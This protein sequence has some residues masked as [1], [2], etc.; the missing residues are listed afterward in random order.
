MELDAAELG[1]EGE[2]YGDEMN[3]QDV[4]AA[5]NRVRVFFC[6]VNF[7]CQQ[8]GFCNLLYTYFNT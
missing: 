8:S 1:V 5:G 3:P 2:E 4:A 6:C 7:C